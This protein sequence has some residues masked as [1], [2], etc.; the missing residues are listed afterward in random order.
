MSIPEIEEYQLRQSALADKLAMLSGAQ[1]LE[2]VYFATA[3]SAGV[4]LSR[5]WPTRTDVERFINQYL[6]RKPATATN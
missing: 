1:I 2:L 6:D 5:S 4:V 3:E